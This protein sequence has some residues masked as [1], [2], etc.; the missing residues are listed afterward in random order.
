MTIS[1]PSQSAMSKGC[2]SILPASLLSCSFFLFLKVKESSN[3]YLRHSRFVSNSVPSLA[4]YLP[5]LGWVLGVRCVGAASVPSSSDK[6]CVR[7]MAYERA[8][9]KRASR[10]EAALRQLPKSRVCASEFM[11][12]GDYA[13]AASSWASGL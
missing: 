8:A 7:S 5:M 11:P 9:R 13:P 1:Q 2:P 3:S 12:L 6:A 4:V 10:N